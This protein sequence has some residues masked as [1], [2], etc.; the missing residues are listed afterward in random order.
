MRAVL[1]SA[2]LAA[3][4]GL[5][6]LA[7][8]QSGI[9]QVAQVDANAFPA[10]DLYVSVLGP[11]GIPRTGLTAQAFNVFENGR[12]VPFELRTDNQ[13]LSIVLVLDRS[14][15]MNDSGKLTGAKQ[16]LRSFVGAFKPED[17]VALISFSDAVSLDQPL[18]QEKARVLGALDGIRAGGQTALFDAAIRAQDL[19]RPLS[20]RKAI[21][22]LTDG[23]DNQSSGTIE[24]VEERAR[25]DNINVYTLGLGTRPNPALGVAGDIDESVLQRMA[26]ASAGEYFYAPDAAAL[27]GLYSRI[28]QQLGSEYK[29]RYQSPR[30]VQDGT[31]R[32]VEVRIETPEASNTSAQSSYVVNGVL[33]RTGVDWVAFVVILLVL[34][35]LL[36]P[37]G[38]PALLENK[39]VQWNMRP[40]LERLASGLQRITKQP[41]VSDTA[42]RPE[43][44]EIVIDHW[45]FIVGAGSSDDVVI[46]GSGLG[47]SVAQFEESGP[48][49]MVRVLKRGTAVRVS[50]NGTQEQWRAVAEANALVDGSLVSFE[51]Q[52]FTVRSTPWRVVRQ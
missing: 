43:S 23:G 47:A 40:V 38:V 21:V 50:V 46:A 29:L 7:Y 9:A 30:A 52:V 36:Y 34:A 11:S 13:G 39:R 41:R 49:L 24:N 27:A 33:G 15:S 3:F 35:G 18:S 31:R 2:V 19:A 22:L 10:V 12:A 20:G 1:S 8:G 26:A 37:G 25:K 42:R 16:A 14:G 4:I 44:R 48:R 6:T 45:P 28:A 5:A 17:R 51:K 32:D